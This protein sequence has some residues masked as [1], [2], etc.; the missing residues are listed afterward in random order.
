MSLSQKIKSIA[1]FLWNDPSTLIFFPVLVFLVLSL[2]AP[3]F[4]IR[5]LNPKFDPYFKY[6]LR[7]IQLSPYCLSFAWARAVM[8]A[9]W[10]T[11]KEVFG[12]G[13]PKVLAF[14]FRSKVDKNTLF[15]CRITAYNVKLLMVLLGVGLIHIAYKFL[16]K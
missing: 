4:L 16:S 5:R 7:Y 14:D 2:I 11:Q 12:K 15:L 9:C 3:L 1:T 8:Y 6:Y 13:Q 10:V